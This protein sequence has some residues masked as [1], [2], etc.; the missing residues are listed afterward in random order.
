MRYLHRIIELAETLGLVVFIEYPGAMTLLPENRQVI[1]C[2]Q[3]RDEKTGAISWQLGEDV[4][5]KTPSGIQVIKEA[6]KLD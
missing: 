3:K 4:T 1:K 5:K 2:V 6:I